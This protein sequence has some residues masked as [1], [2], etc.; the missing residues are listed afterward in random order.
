MDWDSF[1]SGVVVTLISVL[2][3]VAL[4]FLINVDRVR[5]YSFES[6][7]Q[8]CVVQRQEVLRCYPTEER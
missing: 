1:W 6:Q 3:I 8:T 2:I 7:K 5:L 4:V